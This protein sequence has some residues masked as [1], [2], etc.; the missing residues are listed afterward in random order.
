MRTYKAATFQPTIRPDWA[1]ILSYISEKE[2]AEI[3][4]AIIKYPSV[5]C[6]SAFWKETIKPDLDNQYQNFKEACEA[7]SRGVRERWGK[8]STTQVK[9]TTTHVIDA[10]RERERIEEEES[11]RESESGREKVRQIINQTAEN[12]KLTRKTNSYIKITTDLVLPNNAFFNAYRNQ[13]PEATARTE[14]WLRTSNMV[15]K[16]ITEKKI[17]EIIQKFSKNQKTLDNK[18]QIG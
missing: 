4:V 10:E 12:M 18:N 16:Q 14:R 17:G 6:D 3:L 8:I 5:E 9:T 1:G 13:L 15:G 11:G 2:K 7:K